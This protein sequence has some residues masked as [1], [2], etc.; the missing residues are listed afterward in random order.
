[1]SLLLIAPDR[2]AQA[3][4]QVFDAAGEDIILGEAA[5]RDPA[6]VTHLACWVP[7]ADLSRYPNL[8]LLLSVGAGVDQM[9]ALPPS[10]RL[11]RTV[12]P[13]ISQMVRDWVVMA[14]LMLHRDMPLYLEQARAGLWRDH[15][16]RPAAQTRVG[17]MGLGRIGQLVATSLGELG[18]DVAGYSRSGRPVPGVPVSGPRDH[19]AFLGRCDILICLLP[20]TDETRGLLDDALFDA[21]PRGARLVHA[22]RGAQLDMPALRRALDDGRLASAMLDVTDPEPLPET[23]WAWGHPGLI[24]TPHVGSVTDDRDGA[25]HALQVI[26]ADRAGTTIPGL[27]DGTAGY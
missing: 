27:I 1:M 23:H 4:K 25:R 21:L 8:R 6:A 12:I 20:L 7:P 26:A 2:R 15:L 19:A 22:G 10:V 3:W 13:G 11:A 9:P 14:T 18:F 16:T 17:I 24:V 5:V